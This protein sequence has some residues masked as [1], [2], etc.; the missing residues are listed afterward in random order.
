MALVTDASNF[1]RPNLSNEELAA[2]SRVDVSLDQMR[3]DLEA[4]RGESIDPS[5]VRAGMRVL[6]L[7]EVNFLERWS[8]ARFEDFIR[9]AIHVAQAGGRPGA[10]GGSI[11]RSH[12]FMREK[13][14][15]TYV[16]RY[17]D[18]LGKDDVRC[19]LWKESMAVTNLFRSGRADLD[20]LLDH[21]PRIRFLL[22]V[23]N[24]LDCA[25]SNLNIGEGRMLSGEASLTIER[26][27]DV[28]LDS[29]AWFASWRRRHPD[30]FFLSYQDEL[31]PRA[32]AAFLEIE[33][34][35]RWVA[36]ALEAYVLSEGYEHPAELVERLRTR[37]PEVF[38]E[39]P[40][41][42]ERILQLAEEVK[43]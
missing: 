29:I 21:C 33:P 12:A 22:P 17:G 39:T 9:Y 23:R 3:A 10:T 1:V 24:P 14:R 25:R 20:V 27:V 28:V 19:L 34:E 15:A 4:A 16:R 32:L 43:R 36:D 35:E 18:D 26:A 2:L 11:T 42:G 37:V 40:E 31:D 5:A 6:P 8:P 13:T 41:V 38:V 30:R 7:E